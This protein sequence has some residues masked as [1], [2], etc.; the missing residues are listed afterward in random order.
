MNRKFS[1]VV[2]PKAFCDLLSSLKFKQQ[3][4]QTKTPQSR[5]WWRRKAVLLW[6]HYQMG[7]QWTL[8][9]WW[10]YETQC[11]PPFS[12]Q[13]DI[14]YAQAEERHHRPS[15]EEEITSGAQACGWDVC[16]G[17]PKKLWWRCVLCAWMP[18][19][20][21]H[22]IGLNMDL[23]VLLCTANC[24]FV[25]GNFLMYGIKTVSWVFWQASSD[26]LAEEE[27]PEG[28]SRWRWDWAPHDQCGENFA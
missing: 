2:D 28:A 13:L 7:L 12:W 5:C 10:L 20:L 15:S 19:L 14:P 17:A 1:L 26:G 4:D 25:M 21:Y 3:V 24:A 23:T 11:S 16:C 22:Y 18:P 6:L 9:L 27:H 8:I